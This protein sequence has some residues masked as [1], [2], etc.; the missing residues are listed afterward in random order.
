MSH[1]NARTNAEFL[2]FHPMPTFRALEISGNLVT[3]TAGLGDDLGHLI[4]LRLGTAEGTELWK[5]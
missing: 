4:D 1:D 3:G 5:T 2:L